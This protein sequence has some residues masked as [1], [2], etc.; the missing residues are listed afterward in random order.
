V[1]APYAKPFELLEMNSVRD[2]RYRGYC[3]KDMGDFAASVF[4]F[5]GLKDNIYRLV[6]D[7]TLLESNYKKSTL[8]YF[9][10]FYEIINNPKRLQN[11]FGYPCD[12]KGTGNVVIKG[13]RED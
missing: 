10:D 9:D 6:N 8:R 12:K 7:C 5:N 4:L 11:E 13:L 3:I 1:S 2:R